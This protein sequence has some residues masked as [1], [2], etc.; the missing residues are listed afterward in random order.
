MLIERP[1]MG[2]N[3][4]NT[5]GADISDALIREIADAMVE[6]GLRD[7]GYEYVVIDDCWS[8]KERDAEGKLVPDPEKFPNGMKALADY[9]HE[10]GL[11]FGMYACSGL[12]TCAGFPGSYQHEF[13]DAETFASWDVDYL[14][15]DNCMK[16]DVPSPAL[17]NT[18]GMALRYVDRDIVYSM[19]NWG[20]DDSW[21]WARS[22]GASLYRST[23][24]ISD[25]YESMRDIALSQLKNL[26]YTAPG[27]YNDIDMLITGMY[28]QGNVA[29]G[30]CYEGEYL[31][32]F[33]LWCFLQSP[34]MIGCDIRQMSK[35]TRATLLNRA[36]IA[37]NQDPE[38]RQPFLVSH[39]GDTFVYLKH[40][41]DGE[42]AIGMFNF[43]ETKTD[44]PFEFYRIGLQE[45]TGYGFELTDVI[46]GEKRRESGS[47]VAPRVPGHDFRIY[48]A[49][50]RTIESMK[51]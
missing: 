5:F 35:A 34:L 3:S 25:N 21:K 31:L 9:V 50:L 39:Y 15:L 46:S 41:H 36:L 16:P 6:S 49:K 37:I 8:L 43:G 18:M 27:C 24:D 42:Y 19:C 23:G 13:V 7:A 38:C 14:K 26:P 12:Y 29:L 32:H 45:S 10:K 44:I 22:V 30:G 40:L 2:W 11:K 47:F 20:R 51:R 33:A 48:R 17:Y 28:G 1:P 4:W